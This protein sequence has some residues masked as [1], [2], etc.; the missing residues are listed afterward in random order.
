MTPEEIRE[1]VKIVLDELSQRKQ[2]KPVSY[3]AVLQE[4]DK[5]LY[6]YFKGGR[7]TELR[8]VLNR[9][10]DD[11]YIDIIY[12]Q[13]RDGKT[14]EWIAEIMDKDTSTIKRNKKRLIMT[15]YEALSMK[16]E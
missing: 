10:S 2:Y 4:V 16:G 15:I 3:S 6:K 13:Y 14:L 12:L 7:D 8:Q 11:P 9:L 5:R 1:V